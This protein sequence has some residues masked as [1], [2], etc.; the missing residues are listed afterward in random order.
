M[1]KLVKFQPHGN[2]ILVLVIYRGVG[3]SPAAVKWYMGCESPPCGA[4][5]ITLL[6]L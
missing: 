4:P 5:V 1:G 6:M 3:F 2:G